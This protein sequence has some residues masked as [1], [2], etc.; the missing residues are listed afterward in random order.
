MDV[1]GLGLSVIDYLCLIPR[2]PHFEGAV[3]MS[4]FSIQG[5]GP[6]ATAM[7]AL[8]RLGAR[9]GFVGKVSDDDLGRLKLKLFADEG[10]DTRRTIVDPTGTSGFVIVLVE[11]TSGKRAFIGSG[12]GEIPLRPEEVDRD[13]V[14]SAAFLHLDGSHM[15]A[16]HQAAE[17]MRAAGG[18]VSLDAG[19]VSEARPISP[20]MRRLVELSHVVVAAESF[21]QALTGQAE[22]PAAAQALLGHGP[23][24]VAVTCG[25]RGSWFA[26]AEGCGHEPAFAVKV[27]DTTG[28]GDTY[29]GAFLYGLLQ[30]WELRRVTRFA[31]AVAA[32][33]C[34]KLGGRAGIP[35]LHEAEAFLNS[36]GG[37]PTSC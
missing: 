3:G 28:A 8:A 19:A 7:V 37:G 11:E 16:V 35:T 33:K 32:L 36:Q 10:V 5:G 34:R 18:K 4:D 9:A 22:A 31:N 26:T 12:R 25:E 15:A 23:E 20:G 2:I 14:T 27:V 29:H 17:W 21:A 1:V 24:I 30:G 6:V 13:Y